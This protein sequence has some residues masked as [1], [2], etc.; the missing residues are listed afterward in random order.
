MRVLVLHAHPNPESFNAALYRQVVAGLSARGHG[1]DACDLYDEDFQPVMSRAE[2]LGYHASPDNR[3]PVEDHVR[4]LEQAEALVLVY[5]VWNFGLPAILKGYLDRVFLPG[6]SF[7]L[8]EG[9]VRPNLQHIGKLMVVTSYGGPRWR[10][11]LIGD[12]PRTYATRTLR[13][14]IRPAGSMQ[15]L[16]HYDMNRSTDATRAAFMAR[17]DAALAGF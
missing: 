1:V 10:A 3:G 8:V 15:Y 6:V 9:R 12:P 7:K 17:V 11:F 14:L 4:R 16:A 13:A 5:P 2:R